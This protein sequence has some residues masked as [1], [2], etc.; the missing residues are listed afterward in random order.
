MKQLFLDGCD[1]EL[2]FVVWRAKKFISDTLEYMNQ[3]ESSSEYA[4]S[5]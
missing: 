4:E 3:Q 1:Q 2:K 5:N